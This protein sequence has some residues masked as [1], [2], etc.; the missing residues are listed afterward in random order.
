MVKHIVM[1]KLKEFA[2]GASKQENARIL[3]SRLESLQREIE[4][5]KSLEV[6]VNFNPTEVAYDVVLVAE[7]EDKQALSRYQNHPEHQRLITELLDK[8]RLEKKVV[9]YELTD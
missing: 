7:F 8:I 3:R 5:V 9:D 4:E 2:D 1:W 6:G